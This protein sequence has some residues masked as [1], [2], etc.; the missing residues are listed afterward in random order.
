[1]VAARRLNP[2]G[3]VALL[4]ERA[5]RRAA[6]RVSPAARQPRRVRTRCSEEIY[7]DAGNEAAG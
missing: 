1:M 4:V 6:A 7:D 3:Y 2:L 5:Y